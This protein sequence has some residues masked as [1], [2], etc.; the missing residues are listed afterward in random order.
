MSRRLKIL[1]V[2]SDFLFK[3]FSDDKPI[4]L[5]IKKGIPKDI[6][7]REITYDYARDCWAILL[8]HPS[9]EEVPEAAIIPQFTNFVYDLKEEKENVSKSN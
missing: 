8:E 7:Q 4:K 6:I 1:Y 2:S 9:F 5:I 3:L